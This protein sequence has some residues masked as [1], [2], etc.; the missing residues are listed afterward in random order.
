M[1]RSHLQL[2][3]EVGIGKGVY[4]FSVPVDNIED[5]DDKE[6]IEKRDYRR[7]RSDFLRFHNLY[8]R[9]HD[10]R[11]QHRNPHLQLSHYDYIV[12]WT[13]KILSEDLMRDWGLILERRTNLGLKLLARVDDDNRFQGFM[14]NIFEYAQ[15][16]TIIDTVPEEYAQLTLIQKFALLSSDDIVNIHPGHDGN[17]TATLQLTSIDDETK[18]QILS[19][20]RNIIGNDN[21]FEAS[22]QLGLYEARFESLNQIRYVAD[23]LDI[24]QSIQSFPTFHVSPTKFNMVQFTQKLDIEAVDIDN[25]PIVGVIDTGIRDVPV[26]NP[27]VVDRVCIEDNMSV[28]C[29]HGTNVASLVIF[30]RQ[31]LFEHLIPHARV[32][33]I[34]ALENENGQVSLRKLRQKILYG[35]EHYHIKIF[36][37]SLAEPNGMEINGDISSYARMLDEIAYHY[38]VL[39]VTATGN[40]DW[41]GETDLPSVPESL[42]DPQ[43]PTQTRFTNIGSPAENMNGLTVGAVNDATLPATYTKKSHLDFSMP[44]GSSLAEQAIVNFNLMKPDILAEGGDDANDDSKWIEV[45]DGSNINFIKK[46]VGTSFATPVVANLCA[47]VLNTYPSLGA[48]AIKAI[49][50][51]ST[52]STGVVSLPATKRLADQRNAIL[53]GNSHFKKYHSQ[54]PEHIARMIEGHGTIPADDVKIVYSGNNSVTFVGEMEIENEQIKC[55]NI[56]FP[57]RLRNG[58]DRENMLSVSATLCFYAQTIP[59]NDIVSYNPYHVSFRFLHGSENIQQVANNI[60]YVR[61]E[62]HETRE[63]KFS[64]NHIKSSLDRW[65]ESPLPSYK[66]RL[67]SN[68]QHKEFLLKAGDIINVDRNIALAFRCVTKP[69]FDTAPVHFSYVVKMELNN[70]SILGTQF[71]LYDELSA[72]NIVQ[73]IGIVEATAEAEAES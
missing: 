66:K 16:D 41:T 67:F 17:I 22:P 2:L 55:V 71:S 35:I 40:T 43:D 68:T 31:S 38:D 14:A 37:V 50:I 65:S 26:I 20:L 54:T 6:I 47:Q 12:I 29:G 39:F 42:Y 44:I 52:F 4:K 53:R 28:R 7:Q 25:L 5:T 57:E 8:S 32:F 48:S 70:K 15:D 3:N 27:F 63:A 24:F 11:I 19:A 34:Q 58:N 21:L 13:Y 49:L 69:N 30:G 23:N 18:M 56:K 45:I 46:V 62:A 72:I 1:K 64:K 9:Q 73:A 33:S 51:N 60:Q 59:G 36:N 61:G 10:L